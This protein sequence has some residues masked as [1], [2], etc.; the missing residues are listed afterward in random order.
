MSILQ[1]LLKPSQK[2]KSLGICIPNHAKSPIEKQKA[3]LEEIQA[4]NERILPSEFEVEGIYE[5]KTQIT[6]SGEVH[7]GRI[8]KDSKLFY[9]DTQVAIKEIDCRGKIVDQLLE[10]EKGSITIDPEFYVR[11]STNDLLEFK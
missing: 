2:K 6:I 1:S 4:I 11:I 10:G 5:L 8:T 9:D 7:L 3:Q